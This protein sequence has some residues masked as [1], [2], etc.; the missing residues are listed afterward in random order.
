VAAGLCFFQ[1]MTLNVSSEG[2]RGASA[3]T[4]A[5]EKGA[6]LQEASEVFEGM[7]GEGVR[8]NTSERYR[9]CL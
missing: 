6:K 8:G 7:L 2:R 9:M 3:A 5:C 1:R 4:I